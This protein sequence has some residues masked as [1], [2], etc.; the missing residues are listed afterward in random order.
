MAK[1]GVVLSGC[2][3]ARTMATLSTGSGAIRT[4]ASG[5]MV[6]SKMRTSSVSASGSK[7]S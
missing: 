1:V 5:W 4:A 6:A 3:K 7:I 2:W